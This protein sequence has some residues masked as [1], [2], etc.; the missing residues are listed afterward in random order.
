MPSINIEIVEPGVELVAHSGGPA[1]VESVARVSTD[2]QP[3]GDAGG[4][5]VNRLIANGHHSP[6][7]FVWLDF[8]IETSRSVANELVRHR[9][10]SYC[11]ESTR[12]VDARRRFRVILPRA[13]HR[14]RQ[15]EL[16]LFPAWMDAVRVAAGAYASM[17]D[18][19]LERD[20]ARDILPL[21]TAT[22]IRVGMNMRAFRHFLTLRLDGRAAIDMQW[23]AQRM[24]YAAWEVGDL[25]IFLLDLEDLARRAHDRS[26]R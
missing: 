10:A 20:A 14:A 4:A 24:F 16:P 9:I 19:G 5:F 2:T 23:I 13:V 7:E 25:R 12:Y 15:D 8:L 1:L 22:R 6:L 3:E 11:Q 17:R 18:A 26:A 21:C